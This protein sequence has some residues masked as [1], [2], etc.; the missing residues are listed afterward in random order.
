MG[1]TSLSKEWI[2]LKMKC[3][4]AAMDGMSGAPL[5]SVCFEYGADGATT[6][7]IGALGLARMRRKRSSAAEALLLRR[8]EEKYLAAQ[9]IGNDPAVMAEAARRLEA[10]NRFD[11]V[12]INMGCPAR[13][14]VGS[15]NGSALLLDLPRAQEILRAVCAAVSM[16]VRLKLRL[17]WD[18]R[19]IV[20][21]ELCRM[22]QDAGCFEIILHGRTREQ[23]YTGQPNIEAMRAV[24]E[25]VQ[26]PLYANGGVTRAQDARSFMEQTGADGVCIG[27]AALKNPWIFQDIALL[28]QGKTPPVRGA[29]ERICLLE[30]LARRLCEQKPE[31]FAICEMRKYASWYLA[32]LSGWHAALERLNQLETLDAFCGALADQ[33][34]WLAQRN[35]LLP[36][37][38][39][40]PA[41]N[42]DTIP[43]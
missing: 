3:L 29:E 12:E 10:L 38:E 15:G 6:E 1:E 8:P 40:A 14:V 13:C 16:P 42:L 20:A 11:A 31:R 24:R 2:T 41:P 21:P 23:R 26:I 34:N 7:M 4:L 35:D 9:L 5:R 27:R 36:H 37:L 19:H 18:D 39:L 22:A 33:L 28:E 25:A 43:R 30:R 32:G 17:G